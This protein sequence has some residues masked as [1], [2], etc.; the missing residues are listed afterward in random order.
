M[1]TML[2][3]LYLAGASIETPEKDNTHTQ[4]CL[5]KSTR[6][7]KG[8]SDKKIEKNT[9]NRGSLVVDKNSQ[10]LAERKSK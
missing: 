10:S 2:T 7:V 6:Y 3:V 1:L 9:C 8:E 4:Y 5:D